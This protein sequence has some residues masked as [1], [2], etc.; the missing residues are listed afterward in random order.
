MKNLLINF[1]LCTALSLILCLLVFSQKINAEVQTQLQNR[2][3]QMAQ[4]ALEVTQQSATDNQVLQ[5]LQT[6]ILNLHTQ[7]LE[8]IVSL[9]GWPSQSLVGSQGVN[10]AVTIVKYSEDLD[11]QQNMLPLIIQ[12]Y[13]N[14]QGVTGQSVADITDLVAIRKGQKQVFGTQYQITQGKLV[15]S[16]IE[17]VDSLDQLRA[18]LN[19]PPFAEFKKQLE[20]TELP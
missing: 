17:N 19:L 12:S 18:E 20:L 4:Q 11:F 9:H 16:P 14:G 10:A 8:E 7:T 15:F 5:Q 3:T 1:H 2:L 13:M 6:D